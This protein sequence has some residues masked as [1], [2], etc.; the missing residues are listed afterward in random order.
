MNENDINNIY[1]T[2]L[3]EDNPD[4]RQVS[5]KR[6]SAMR[7]LAHIICEEQHLQAEILEHGQFYETTGDKGQKLLKKRPQYEE[8][9][10]LRDRKLRYSKEL[11]IT[12]SVHFDADFD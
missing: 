8:L 4:P 6:K 11:G 1:Q 2:L 10:R 7:T 9:G 3:A 12:T 5:F